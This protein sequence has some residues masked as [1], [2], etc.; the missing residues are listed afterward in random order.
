[1]SDLS[2]WCVVAD[3]KVI[4]SGLITW[5]GAKQIVYD[6]AD[7]GMYTDVYV[8]HSSQLGEIK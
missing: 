6:A 7:T 8:L 4:V 1:M 3:D 5:D 2:G